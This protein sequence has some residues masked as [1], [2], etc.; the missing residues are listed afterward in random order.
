M[1]ESKSELAWRTDVQLA[2]SGDKEAF[3][4]LIRAVQ[5]DLYHMARTLL[6]RD[7]DCADALQ[8]TIL[9]AYRGLGNLREP[10]FFRT[11]LFRIL[12]HECGQIRRKDKKVSL[13][14][15]LPA[16]AADALQM[17]EDRDLDV[18][19]AVERLRE[20]LRTAVKLHYFADLPLADIAAMTGVSEGTLKSRL[21]R[22]RRSLAKRLT[23]I[24]D[25]RSEIG[26]E[27][28]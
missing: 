17:Q 19:D 2:C 4:R 23:G 27:L 16:L 20:P 26:Y 11:W 28:P 14:D 25:E 21:H 5:P 12:I 13:S 18:R 9:K 8:E 1:P 15:K 24:G 10:A 3:A 7:E 6:N 22:A